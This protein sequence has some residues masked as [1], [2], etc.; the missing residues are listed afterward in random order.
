M[1]LSYKSYPHISSLDNC[2]SFPTCSLSNSP[3]ENCP[4]D[5]C[6]SQL[7]HGQFPSQ[8]SPRDNCP[9]DFSPSDTFSWL[10]PLLTTIPG[11]LPL[12]EIPPEKGSLGHLP[13]LDKYPWTIYRWRLKI[14]LFTRSSLEISTKFQ[15]QKKIWGDRLLW[16][17]MEIFYLVEILL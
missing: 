16:Y 2:L 11:Q 8:N 6:L 1:W 5:L 10:I 12:H 15:Q 17:F 3:Y 7:P 14:A 13:C 4:P 9:L